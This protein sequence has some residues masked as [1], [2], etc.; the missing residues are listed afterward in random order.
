[1]NKIKRS[2]SL[3]THQQINALSSNEIKEQLCPLDHL[4]TLHTNL[5]K[6]MDHSKERPLNL[7]PYPILDS[8]PTLENLS[9]SSAIS[10][11]P[12]SLSK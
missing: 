3:D 2:Q 7:S 8:D 1:M 4:K 6:K 12:D 10:K 11:S 9:Y 5:H